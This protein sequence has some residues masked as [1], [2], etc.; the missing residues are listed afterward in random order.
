MASMTMEEVKEALSPYLDRIKQVVTNG[1]KEWRTVEDFRLAAGFGP[2]LY[3]RT[4]ANSVFDAIARNSRGA[5]GGDRNIRIHYETQT[6]KCIFDN[7]VIARFKKGDD[8]H[9]GQNI[10][11]QA[12]MDYLDPQHTLPGFPPA[13]KVEIM[14]KADDLG[15]AIEEVTVAARDGKHL[16]WSYRIEDAEE[17]VRAGVVELPLGPTPGEFSPLVVARP[18]KTERES[19]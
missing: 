1:Y 13:A 11:T 18:R 14:W 4:I 6:I 10:P 2:T 8:G 12:V 19:K 3:P 7:T 16:L 5:F 15:T 17:G 9:L